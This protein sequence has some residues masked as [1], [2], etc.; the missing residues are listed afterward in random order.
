MTSGH[1]NALQPGH[2]VHW[3]EIEAIL[4]QGGFGIT[5]LASDTNLARKV[6]IKEYLPVELAVRERDQTVHPVSGEHEATYTWGLG[7]FIEEART[8]AQFKHPNIV[9]VHTVFEA[10]GTAYMVMEFEAGD[11]FQERLDG[12]C[13]P[14]NELLRILFPILD[15]L[16]L[17]HAAGFIHRDIKPANIFIRADGRPVL[18]DFGSS[19]QAMGGQTRTLTGLVSPG[20]AP[21][22][23]YVAK[24]NQQGPWTDIYGLGA[25][26]YR[27]ASGHVPADAM[28]RSEALLRGDVDP[29]E[30][31]A[32]A[33]A[34]YSSAFIAAVDGALNFPPGDRPQSVADWRRMFATDGGPQAGDPARRD[35]MGEQATLRVDTGF[36]SAP[37]P[38]GDAPKTDIERAQDEAARA[39]GR[40]R[41]LLL[42]L[43]L[44]VAGD[45]YWLTRGHVV[46]DAPAPALE[47]RRTAEALS[48]RRAALLRDAR[49]QLA[50]GRLYGPGNDNALAQFRLVLLLDPD[51]T[52]AATG[53][54]EVAARL[55]QRA[56]EHIEQGAVDAAEQDIERAAEIAP[57]HPL[58]AGV[59]GALY[60]AHAQAAQ[61]AAATELYARAL[62]DIAAGRLTE[63]P[64]DNALDRAHALR[65]AAPGDARA[66]AIEKRIVDALVLRAERALRVGDSSLAADLH[67]QARRLHP[68][69]PSV[70]EMTTRLRKAGQGTAP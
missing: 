55:V 63:P 60:A 65:E 50:A 22:E 68:N 7:K 40:I 56:R 19:R 35:V 30:P 18:L 26:L 66:E 2:R 47:A 70:Q 8:L 3:Y 20:Y 28:T 16:E 11:S 59:R 54:R 45:I 27:A 13:V 25:T 24:S 51:N 41:V 6:A 36:A 61:Q 64:Y 67:R 37:R 42:L 5:Y 38:A 33:L 44:A 43:A 31:A 4:G 14:E 62:D 52:D 69:A 57:G 39:Q 10:H 32:T 9:R 58:L 34:G 48:A 29:Y 49:R 46:L 15:G 1:R 21:F 53:V 17:V 23:Q 12:R